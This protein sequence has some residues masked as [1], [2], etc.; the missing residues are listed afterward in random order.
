MACILTLIGDHRGSL[1]RARADAVG[2]ALAAAG[3]QPAAPDWLSPDRACDIR[4]TGLVPAA[5]LPAARAALGTAPVDA[6]AQAEAGRRKRLLVADMDSTIVVEETLDRMATLGGIVDAV[7][8]ITARAMNGEIDFADALRERVALLAGKPAAL[9]DAAMRQVHLTPGARALIAT[10]RRAGVHTALVSG[11]FQPF[12]ERVAETLGFDEAHANRLE[13]VGDRLTGRLVGDIVTRETKRVLLTR[14]AAERGVP[15]A[16]TLT[17]GDGANDLP[18]LLAA[19]LGVAFRAKPVVRQA[20]TAVVDHG[21]L[22]ALLYL[23][24]YRDADIAWPSDDS[25]AL[26]GARPA[27][28]R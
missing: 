28:T 19:G 21:D 4:V 10:L 27:A 18:M 13:I 5:V 17:V 11:G 3:G 7:L 16:E 25:P 8:P 15:P 24:G 2:A 1:S 23:Q 14:R 6:V 9:I 26:I 12:A 20:V 22:T